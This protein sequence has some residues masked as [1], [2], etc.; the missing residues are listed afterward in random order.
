MSA[1]EGQPPTIVTRVGHAGFGELYFRG[2]RVFAELAG[3]T[4][5]S[6]MTA[7]AI[8]G[9]RLDATESG[10]LDDVAACAAFADPR[11]WALKAAR[12][13]ASYGSSAAGV[14]AAAMCCEGTLLGPAASHLV[15]LMLTAV[16]EELGPDAGDPAAVERVMLGILDRG[17]RLPGFG[18]PGHRGGRATDERLTAL[19]G[20]LAR[21]GWRGSRYVPLAE[22]IADRLRRARGLEANIGLFAAA[23]FLDLGFEPHQ[24]LLISFAVLYPTVLGNVAEEAELQSASL[25][26]L[27]DPCVSYQGVPARV[28]PRALAARG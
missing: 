22:T 14:A 16:A 26:R 20:T 10:V 7:L 4:S 24:V 9:R 25:H 8:T 19:R 2:Y 6:A 27:P 18:V 23:I 12:L 15:A 5:L 21:R 13:A 28:S 11:V 3:R 17:G 1:P